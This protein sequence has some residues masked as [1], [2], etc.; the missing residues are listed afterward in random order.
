MLAV[1]TMGLVF[2]DAGDHTP[3]EGAKDPPS[4]AISHTDAIREFISL[5]Q[6]LRELSEDR[7]LSA[8]S[9]IVTHDSPL[10]RTATH[11]IRQLIA[12]KVIDRSSFTTKQVDVTSASRSE[13]AITQVVVIEPRFIHERTGEPLKTS[14]AL[15]QEVEWILRYESGEWKVHDALVISSKEIHQ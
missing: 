12:D 15:R 6:H 3:E 8:L 2:C 9:Q 10:I 7:D 11:D 13:I 5:H 4:H 1:L 14:H